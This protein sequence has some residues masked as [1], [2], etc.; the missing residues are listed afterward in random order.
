MLI[1]FIFTSI[2]LLIFSLLNIYFIFELQ[3]NIDSFVEVYNFIH[4][5][6]V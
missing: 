2:I 3:T 5:K 4:A 6:G 1:L